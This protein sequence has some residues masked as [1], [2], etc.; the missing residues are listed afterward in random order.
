MPNTE[1]KR[2]VIYPKDIQFI[3][4]QSE[5]TCRKIIRD[6]KLKLGKSKEEYVTIDEFCAHKGIDKNSILHYIY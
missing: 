5:S 3:T 6:I 2:V 1:L 4:G